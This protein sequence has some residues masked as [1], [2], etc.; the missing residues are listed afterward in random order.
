MNITHKKLTQSTPL[1]PSAAEELARC[2][3]G[4]MPNIPFNFTSY[5][6]PGSSYCQVNY[7][8]AL[9]DL[10]RCC[11]GGKVESWNNCTQWCKTDSTLNLWS[12]C[13]QLY[14][15]DVI[16]KLP[17]TS[18]VGTHCGKAES[19]GASSLSKV[20]WKGSVVILLAAFAVIG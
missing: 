10:M 19:S 16:T 14:L 13:V 6:P 11:G 3:P 12:N 5:F 15:D 4:E 1:G 7:P 17:G 20:H 18:T 9:T 2:R 8:Y